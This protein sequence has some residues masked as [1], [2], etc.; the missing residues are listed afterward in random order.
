MLTHSSFY[1]TVSILFFFFLR[2]GR[3]FNRLFAVVI[4][5]EEWN[6]FSLFKSQPKCCIFQLQGLCTQNEDA[7]L[8][9]HA[10]CSIAC[11]H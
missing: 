6:Y 9:A 7:C 1:L 10:E 5:G 3:K 8:M 2:K 4:K 11:S